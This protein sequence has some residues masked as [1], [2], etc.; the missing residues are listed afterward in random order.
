MAAQIGADDVDFATPRPGL[1][2]EISGIEPEPLGVHVLLAGHGVRS[3]QRLA[4]GDV[5]GGLVAALWPG[6][7]K[8]QALHLYRAGRSIAMI[9]A[10]RKLGWSAR[11][12]PHIG[13]FNSAAALRLY[14]D[15]EIDAAEF[16]RR[17][18]ETDGEWIRQY[19][20]DEVRSTLWPWLKR[21][22]YADDGDADEVLDRFL[23]I[24]GK[25]PAH[26]PPRLA[27][28]GPMGV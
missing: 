1:L 3:T 14:L 17:W 18:E 21:R 23:S 6:E 7:L 13:F 11:P 22:G 27:A 19:P 10:A 24:L 16:A 25:R 28:Q 5:G 26:P 4:L 2:R 20:R 12:S 8:P 15:P 9:S